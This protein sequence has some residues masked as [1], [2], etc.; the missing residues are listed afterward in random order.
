MA[1]VGREFFRPPHIGK[2]G[3]PKNRGLLANNRILKRFKKTDPA[4]G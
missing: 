2:N 3:F 4:A 1:N